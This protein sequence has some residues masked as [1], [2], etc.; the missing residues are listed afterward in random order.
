MA[1]ETGNAQAAK[2][3]LSKGADVNSK[4]ESGDTP[5]HEAIAWGQRGLQND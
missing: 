4:N 3:L 5:L 2:L 1:A